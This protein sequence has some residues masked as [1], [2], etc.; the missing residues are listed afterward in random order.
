MKIYKQVHDYYHTIVLE[1]KKSEKS[2]KNMDKILYYPVK[3]NPELPTLNE[4]P[5]PEL[6]N[7][8]SS[9]PRLPTRH[10]TGSKLLLKQSIK[11]LRDPLKASICQ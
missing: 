1:D 6:P 4:L 2:E 8:E 9:D 11:L 10:R 5:N 3:T 7:P